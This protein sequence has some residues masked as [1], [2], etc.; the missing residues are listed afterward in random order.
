MESSNSERVY[1]L[2]FVLVGNSRREVEVLVLVLLIEAVDASY[3]QNQN[4]S[5]PKLIHQELVHP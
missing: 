4:F 1:H 2:I 3:I 5:P